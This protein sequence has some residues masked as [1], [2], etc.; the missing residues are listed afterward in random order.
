MTA[1]ELHEEILIKM[2]DL[3]PDFKMHPLHK[4]MLMECCENVL[5]PHNTENHSHEILL[6]STLQ[7]FEVSNS[8]MKGLIKGMIPEVADTITL[9]YRGETF[10]LD[11]ESKIVKAALA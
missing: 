1:E 7:A 3:K 2:A 6:I 9:N 5:Q 4:A 8:L 10:I 11:Q